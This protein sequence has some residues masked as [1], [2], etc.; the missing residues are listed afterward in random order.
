MYTKLALFTLAALLAPC[1]SATVITLTLGDVSFA[2]QTAQTAANFTT[3]DTG[4]LSPFNGVTCGSD[5]ASNCSTSWT[6]SGYSI[7]IGETISSVIFSFGVSELDTHA[8]GNQ[9]ASL[10]VGGED[11]TSSMNTLAESVDLSFGVCPPAGGG[12][13]NCWSNVYRQY[14]LA[15]AS[16]TFTQVA[17]GTVNVSFST[18]NGW[19]LFGNTSFNGVQLD[20]ST[21]TITTQSAS[22]VPEPGAVYSMFAGLAGI[23]AIAYRRRKA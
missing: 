3:A 1:A 21:L 4:E 17:T 10:L 16:P 22:A 7:P 20:Y 9:V 6:F 14:S 13:N 5:T 11:L 23:S 19:G 12:S 15:L 2:D 8:T 18:Q